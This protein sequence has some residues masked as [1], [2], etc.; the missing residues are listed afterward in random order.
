[1]ERVMLTSLESLQYIFCFLISK[2]VYELMI[3]LKGLSIFKFANFAFIVQLLWNATS[4]TLSVLDR[5]Y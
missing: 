5:N 2:G 3:N 1:M 4:L